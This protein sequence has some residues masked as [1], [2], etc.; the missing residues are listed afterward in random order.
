M[1]I[2]I[3]YMNLSIK[4][5]LL[6]CYLSTFLL[7]Q[8][9]LNIGFS[10]KPYMMMSIVLILVFLIGSNQKILILNKKR[11]YEYFM[12]IFVLFATIRNCFASDIILGF[13]GSVALWISLF[14]Y[15]FTVY[16]FKNINNNTIFHIIYMS[17][18]TNVIIIAIGF[19]L[20]D[21]RIFELDRT[22]NR[23]RGYVQD[24]NFFALYLTLPLFIVLY[25]FIKNKKKMILTFAMLTMF[26]LSYSRAGYLSIILGV[27]YLIYLLK[28]RIPNFYK[29]SIVIGLLIFIVLIV[30]S[31][32]STT[33]PIC[34]RVLGN[35][36]ARFNETASKGAR[37]TLIRIGIDVFKEN[38]IF[39][40]GML[41]VRYYTY[42]VV[43]N[44]YLHNT[45]LEAFVE[46]GIVGGLI[47]L[48]FIISFLMEKCN[49][50]YAKV[51]KAT[52]ICQFIMMFFLSAINSEALFLS[53]GLFCAINIKRNKQISMDYL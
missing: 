32:L 19:I 24:P 15:F 33:K 45:Y 2:V 1:N 39:G 51:L 7:I 22:V 34:E 8:F 41:N 14:V 53:L 28:N 29:K 13:K 20:K 40:V 21:A 16:L 12:I 3:K 6:A 47:Y 5:I 31:S 35:I 38:P 9:S 10:F 17:A 36:S 18:I 50:I 30:F 37:E 42:S 48:L 44:S 26:F 25:Y 11:K 23:L 52:I 27:L 43:H 49:N 46:Q 4:N